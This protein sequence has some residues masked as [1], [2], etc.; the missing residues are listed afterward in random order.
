MEI[1]WVIKVYRIFLKFN[2]F[3][4]IVIEGRVRGKNIENLFLINIFYNW[5]IIRERMDV[6]LKCFLISFSL[7][8]IGFIID[9]NLYYSYK[10][11]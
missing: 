6:V 11:L 4:L 1:C 9:I 8:R 5:Y 2:I 10:C 3:I 7:F